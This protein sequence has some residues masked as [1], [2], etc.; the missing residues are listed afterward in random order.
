MKLLISA[1]F[2]GNYNHC[3]TIKAAVD[4]YKPDIFVHAGDYCP[5]RLK[6]SNP[7][8]AI[9]YLE[10]YFFKYIKELD[11]PYKFAI[12]GNTDLMAVTDHF[13]KKY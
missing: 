9:D 2:H 4:R 12:A 3:K 1:D 10:E 7:S 8:D 6:Y 11:V 5:T 13:V